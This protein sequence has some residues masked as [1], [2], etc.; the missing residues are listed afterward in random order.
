MVRH[1]LLLTL[2]D[3]PCYLQAFAY[4]ANRKKATNDYQPSRE[5]AVRQHQRGGQEIDRLVRDGPTP[6]GQV[7]TGNWV[8]LDMALD[9]WF[10]GGNIHKARHVDHA[11]LMQRLGVTQPK[12]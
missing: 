9:R 1:D 5:K 8:E 4:V 6:D 12:D 2:L 10:R 7:S 3:I 11:R